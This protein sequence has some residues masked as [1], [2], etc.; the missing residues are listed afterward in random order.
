MDYTIKNNKVNACP[1]SQIEKKGGGVESQR[2]GGWG[3]GV[4]VVSITKT[5]KK[6]GGGSPDKLYSLK[7]NKNK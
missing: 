1:C 3:W 6:G 2:G 5:K 4:N 7:K